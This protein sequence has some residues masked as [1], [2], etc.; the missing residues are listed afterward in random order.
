MT[1]HLPEYH[2]ADPGAPTVT[3]KNVFESERF[4]PYQTALTKQWQSL[5]AGSIGVLIRLDSATSARIDFGR[6]G[7]HEIPVDATDLVERSNAIR[8]GKA[9]KAAPNFLMAIGP[10]LLDSRS[11]DVRAY[12]F[13]DAAKGRLFLCV[14]AD[15]WRKDFGTLVHALTPLAD[16]P[17]V[18]A[19]LFPLSR[20]PD[21]QVRDQLRAMKWTMPYVYAHLSEPYAR[22][23]LDEKTPR[24]A[25]QLQTSDGRLLYEG[26][27]SSEAVSKLN[28][29]LA[30]ATPNSGE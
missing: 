14:F 24:P 22:T 20:R 17:G 23:L 30:A 9:E 7:L 16:Q 13:D 29:A 21:V 3:A 12:P 1:S 25:V 27:F 28:A 10:R 5:P 11:A 6:D 18:Q 15:P 26:R 19:I 4:W 2:V 8:L